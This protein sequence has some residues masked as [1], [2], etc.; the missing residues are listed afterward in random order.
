ME[1]RL[2]AIESNYIELKAIFHQSLDIDT[3]KVESN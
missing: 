1:K 3:E 2:K